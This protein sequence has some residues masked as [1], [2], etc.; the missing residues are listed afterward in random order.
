GRK[1]PTWLRKVL[2]RGLKVVPEE[3]FPN[4][5]ALLAALAADPGRVR[6]RWLAGAGLVAVAVIAGVTL[7]ER[8]SSEAEVCRGAE[9]LLVGVW[10]E[11]RAAAV[12]TALTATGLPYAR[13]TWPRVQEQ[14]DLYSR[15]W[16]ALHVEVCEATNVHRN[17]SAARM[18]LRMTCLAESL[19]ELRAVVG[20]LAEADAQ[21]A[22]RAVQV[23][24]GLRP[25]SRC[26]DA[27]TLTAGATLSPATATAVRDLDT[28]LVQ[29]RAEH[30][31]GRYA[32]GLQLA[33]EA[34]VAA[35]RSGHDP[36]RAEALYHRGMLEE[37]AGDFAAA[38]RSYEA[39]YWLG[40]A[41]AEDRVRAETAVALTELV[42]ER[43]GRDHDSVQWGR[44]AE[45]LL[46]RLGDP[47]DLE[48]L[49]HAA[50]GVVHNRYGRYDDALLALDRAIA[51]TEPGDP[52]LTTFYR[53]LG[54]VHYRRGH[55]PDAEAA[56]DRAVELGESALGPDH[57]DLARSISN[58]GESHRIQGHVDEAERCFRRSIAI[59]EQAFGP[60]HSL[61]AP[62]YNGLGTLAL[63]RGDTRAAVAHFERVRSLL[64]GSYGPDHPDVGAVTSNL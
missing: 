2:L 47:T 54:N 5:D 9:R 52:R 28:L 6:K 55:Y 62:P 31:A 53:Q 18:D 24:T 40:E 63:L 60:E 22:E 58:L 45:A 41:V 21:V 26:A 48:A 59:W 8:R 32:R 30:D 25:L 34:V 16:Q 46:H 4:I 49:L 35:D 11:Q 29:V 10:D 39:A 36:A 50:L 14:L 37:G 17:Q 43:L 64:S 38:E 1:I 7:A 15:S 20:V 42:G 3:R 44:H 27:T 23:A 56:Y 61:L 51:L 19:A 13:D 12:Q 33:R 57:P